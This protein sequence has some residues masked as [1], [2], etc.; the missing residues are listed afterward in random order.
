[1]LDVVTNFIETDYAEP[2]LL[3]IWGHTFELD[4]GDGT[5]WGEIE[6]LFKLISG[7]NDIFYGT[8]RETLL[9]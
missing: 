2:Q 3:Y 1:M 7:K 8:N 5:R 9:N 6:D 4:V